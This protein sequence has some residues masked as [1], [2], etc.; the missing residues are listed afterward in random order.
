MYVI[1]Y[2]FPQ[3]DSQSSYSFGKIQN[4]GE[5]ELS[6]QKSLVFHWRK[7]SYFVF[8]HTYILYILYIYIYE[9][10]I[11]NMKYIYIYIYM[12]N[13]WRKRYKFCIEI[14][15]LVWVIYKSSRSFL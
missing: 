10:E 13:I 12:C 15:D 7:I 11:C 1:I 9:N 5:T 8:I 3:Q 4:V 14:Q 6:E 2:E